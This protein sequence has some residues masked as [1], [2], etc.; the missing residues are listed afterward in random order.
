[1]EV[2][3]C[4]HSIGHP[5]KEMG[6]PVHPGKDMDCP[7]HPGIEMDCTK[8]PGKERDSGMTLTTDMTLQQETC[9]VNFP[10]PGNTSTLQVQ[11]S[12][13][14]MGRHVVK[15]KHTSEKPYMCEECGYR[16]SQKHHLSRHMRIH[17]GE[18][19]Y[20]CDQCDY[21][22]AVKH[23]L[24]D[25]Q[26]THSGEKPYMC[27]EC[28]YR[29][30]KRSTL[31]RH[32]RTHTGEK[33]YKC[34]HCDYSAA[35]RVSL[36]QH[37]HTFSQLQVKQTAKET[38]INDETGDTGWQQDKQE[39][40][41]CQETYSEYN[42]DQEKYDYSATQPTGHPWNETS[43]SWEETTVTGR[44]K[45][46]ERDVPKDET[47]GC[48]Y[49]TANRSHLSRHMKTH[50][51]DRPYMCDQCDYSAAEKHNL[52]DHQTT[53]SGEKPYMCEKCGFR[54]AQRSTLSKHMRIHTG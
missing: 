31:T 19:P 17:T 8:H 24:I 4:E 51:G 29:S 30:A 32:M 23:H 39:N 5:G 10:Q 33:T 44:Q 38:H 49:R 12:R 6:H 2:P 20:R 35:D 9:D 28:G 40:V 48:G 16:A 26:T 7:R 15:L 11:E 22:A 3:S 52:I 43:Y 41:L 50:T 14:S 21:S 54:A 36:D 1:M 45:D 53:H 34:D 47:C 27:G 25:H 13:A 42:E 18:R 37:V 46:E